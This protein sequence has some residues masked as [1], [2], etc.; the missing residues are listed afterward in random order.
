MIWL[1]NDTAFSK[2]GCCWLVIGPAASIGPKYNQKLNLV[3]LD[4]RPI[5]ILG[6]LLYK[7]FSQRPPQL[8]GQLAHTLN[9]LRGPLD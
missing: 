1:I 7:S 4:G 9:R 6:P 2:N 5:R 8:L 3:N